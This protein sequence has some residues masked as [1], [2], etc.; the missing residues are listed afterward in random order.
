[1]P[2][3]MQIDQVGLAPGTPG[4]ARDDGLSTGAVV[5]LTN[6]GGGSTL[7]VNLLWVP[8]L[9]TTAVVSLAPVNP[10]Q[11]H[12]TPTVGV[13][14]RYRIEMVVDL[15]LATESRTVHT[16][17]I[18]LPASG[19][20]I[21]AANEIG[22][23]GT[24]LLNQADASR[25]AA[26]ESNGLQPAPFNHPQPFAWWWWMSAISNAI[27]TL[28][29]SVSSMLSGSLGRVGLLKFSGRLSS[30]AALDI[31][32][33]LSDGLL[34]VAQDAP[35]GALQYP[36]PRCKVTT[37]TVKPI[38][39]NLNSD[40]TVTVYKNGVATALFVTVPA[41]TTTLQQG[42]SL[43]G[44]AFNSTDGLDVVADNTAGG[45]GKILAL[46]AVVELYGRP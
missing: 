25:I 32:R 28:T 33:F 9:D 17:G 23:P 1:M 43:L 41:G 10:T 36:V 8:P 27:E 3:I 24:T 19:V 14:G 21:P 6:S 39:N 13:F 12:F 11:W 38:V 35:A 18:A 29:T 45:A 44:I 42:V 37:L 4:V 34:Q 15:G 2:A 46:S 16:F 26:A 7:K 20:V 31:T 5:T 22:D 40:T 30:D